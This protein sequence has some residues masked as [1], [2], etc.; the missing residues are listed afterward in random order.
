MVNGDPEGP[1]AVFDSGVGGLTVFRAIGELLPQEDLVYFGDT[2]RFPYGPRSVDE[3]AEFAHQISERM[4]S[5]GAKMLVIACNSMTAASY[6]DATGTYDIP[7]VGVIRPGVRAGATATRN[8][9]VGV[10]G[11]GST[12]SSGTY[13]RALTEAD[14]SLEVHTQ[15]CPIFVEKVEA[16]DTFSEELV[17]VA[18]S[19]LGE[20]M[21]AGV[22]TL[23]LGCTHYPLLKGVLHWVTKG[24][25]V[26]ISSA[27]EVAK[28]VYASLVET[29]LLRRSGKVGERRYE[30][31]GDPE[32]F[33][34]VASLFIPGIS[35]VRSRPW[36]ETPQESR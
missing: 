13:Q 3:V 33:M 9:K 2:A 17:S 21:S 14:P 12:I 11:T 1:I 32:D 19:Y 8:G 30:V 16:G 34:R 4:V 7:V 20:M 25:V 31:S 29:G 35:E 23:I 18:E 26:L 27:D 36:V 10:I 22:D 6:P 15:I 28:D 5:D 24:E